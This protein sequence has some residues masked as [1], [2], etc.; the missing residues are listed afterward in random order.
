MKTFRYEGYGIP[1]EN[2]IRGS[3][4]MTKEEV[5]SLTMAKL[6]P[7][8]DE[9]ALDIGAGTGSIS[10]ELAYCCRKVYAAEMKPEALELLASN[11]ERFSRNNMEILSGAAPGSLE[12]IGEPLD[13]LFL[14]G[15]GGNLREIMDWAEDRLKSSGKI[16][17][18]FITMENAVT[19][20]QLLREYEY[21]QIDVT[22]VQIAKGRG[23]GKLTMLMGQNPVFIISA[24]RSNHG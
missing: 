10:V 6:H 15:T 20:L 3:A 14:G 7:G 24:R 19:F 13:I 17:A 23:I 16:A 8:K 1:D 5:R 18:N 21:Q 11:Q 4:P 2:F 12:Q 22:Q 9:V